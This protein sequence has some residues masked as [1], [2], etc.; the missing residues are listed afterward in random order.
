MCEQG[1]GLQA[2][3]GPGTG[4]GLV[5]EPDGV[6]AGS[7]VRVLVCRPGAGPASAPAAGPKPDR[8]WAS[9][10]VLGQGPVR[11]LEL[12]EVPGAGRAARWGG[13]PV[14]EGALKTTW[15]R[16][17]GPWATLHSGSKVIAPAASNFLRLGTPRLLPDNLI[18]V[19]RG[20]AEGGGRLQL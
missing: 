1:G 17:Q 4:P 11:P 14:W 16:S 7:A 3:S 6:L 15:G 9:G 20:R 5:G 19:P 8:A 18:E 2:G 12:A 13:F 10:P